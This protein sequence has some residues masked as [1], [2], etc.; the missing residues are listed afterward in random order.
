MDVYDGL[1]LLCPRCNAPLKEVHT[2]HGVFLGVREL[3]WPRADCCC[4]AHSLRN[5]STRSGFTQL[6]AK[7]EAAAFVLRA[8]NR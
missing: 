2:L 3:R 7:E 6:V 1:E 5:R 8:E 4:V